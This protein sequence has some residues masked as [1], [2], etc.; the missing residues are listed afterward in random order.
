MVYFVVNLLHRVVLSLTVG[1]FVD[2]RVGISNVKVLIQL[3]HHIKSYSLVCYRSRILGIIIIFR[4][5]NMYILS[6]FFCFNLDALPCHPLKVLAH[7]I[8]YFFKS[9][10]NLNY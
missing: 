9:I 3:N 4:L 5:S 1:F 10:S 8:L 6:C 7:I 2:F